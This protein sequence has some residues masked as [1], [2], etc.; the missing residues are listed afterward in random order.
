MMN[1]ASTAG[2]ILKVC[3]EEVLGG[4]DI[5]DENDSALFAIDRRQDV[6]L[7]E[8]ANLQNVSLMSARK[9]MK[10]PNEKAVSSGDDQ[11]FRSRYPDF[12]LW[13]Q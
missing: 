4:V 8:F 1:Y 11:Y 10:Q 3:I 9:A 6:L 2:E 12:P 13:S 5:E 7:R